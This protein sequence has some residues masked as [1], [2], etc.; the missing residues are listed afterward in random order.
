MYAVTSR[1]RI[2]LAALL[3]GALIACG[4]APSLVGPLVNG[5]PS[6]ERGAKGTPGAATPHLLVSGLEGAF[7]ST[8]GPGGAL[9]VAESQAGRISRIDP[10]TGAGTTFAS[11]LPSNAA[12]GGGVF[13][14]AFIG[15]T[16]YALVSLVTPEVGGSGVDG[17]Y[18]MD[19]PNSFT[20]VAD[21]GAFNRAN[22]PETDFF[23]PTGVPFALETFRNGFL[24]TDGHLNR[25]LFV[26]RDGEIGVLR[27]FDNIV[28]TGLAVRGNRVYMAEAGPLPHLPENGRVVAFEQNSATATVIAS[29]A[30]LAVGV[31]FG[32]GN[33][34]F[35]LSQGVWNGA[36][37]GSPA[38]P[39]TGALVQVNDQGGFTT[40][41]G[42][43]DRPISLQIIGNTAYIVTLTGQIWTIE[44]VAEPP[45]GGIAS[46]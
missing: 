4:D 18:R 15:Q 32:R 34:L 36:G 11:G 44:N 17:I 9:F 3:I 25:V 6:L 42:A 45:F 24:V 7:G 33:T 38:L 35:A 12:V 22:P 37:A 21:I 39:N 23:V 30:R 40:V 26:T 31:E 28:P 46:K 19:G 29:G 27:A 16:A 41:V 1:P 10:Q 2:A 5:P 13:D 14:V 8:I 20:I 43:L